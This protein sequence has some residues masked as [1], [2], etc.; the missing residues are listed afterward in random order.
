MFGNGLPETGQRMTFKKAVLETCVQLPMVDSRWRW[1]TEHCNRYHSDELVILRVE[2][3]P[4]FY[5]MLASHRYG[6]D[7]EPSIRPGEAIVTASND[8]AYQAFRMLSFTGT[9]W[10]R[11]L[12]DKHIQQVWP[13]VPGNTLVDTLYTARYRIFGTRSG[14]LAS[15][16]PN[17]SSVPR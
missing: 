1:L 11:L 12:D 10:Q 2:V 13:R 4:V 7:T 17:L 15:S 8:T 5:R 9:E 16:Q 14:R 3:V 6:V